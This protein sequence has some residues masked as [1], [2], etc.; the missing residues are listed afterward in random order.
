MDAVFVFSVKKTPAFCIHMYV[1]FKAVK[2]L[3]K[4]SMASILY[5]LNEEPQNFYTIWEMHTKVW[6]TT[7]CKTLAFIRKMY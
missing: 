7:I 3:C 6:S 4:I 1:T 2:V 5:I